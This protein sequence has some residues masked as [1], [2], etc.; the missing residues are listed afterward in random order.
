[1]D[2]AKT[3]IPQK[4]KGCDIEMPEGRTWRVTYKGKPYPPKQR[5]RTFARV[6]V[7]EA[8]KTEEVLEEQGK[9]LLICLRWVWLW[10]VRFCNCN[11]LRLHF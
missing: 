4:V 9:K 7:T 2:Y 6:G 1:M 11:I 8:S 10:I 3:L 5:E